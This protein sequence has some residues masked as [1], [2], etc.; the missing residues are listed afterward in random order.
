MATYNPKQPYAPFVERE[1]KKV[2]CTGCMFCTE[3]TGQTREYW[4]YNSPYIFFSCSSQYCIDLAEQLVNGK[5]ELMGINGVIRAF[6][7]LIADSICFESDLPTITLGGVQY[8]IDIGGWVSFE[9]LEDRLN[10]GVI[11]EGRGPY[12]VTEDNFLVHIKAYAPDGTPVRIH[13]M[14]VFSLGEDFAHVVNEHD[15]LHDFCDRVL[16]VER[17]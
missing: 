7:S 14:T 11:Y 1:G 5:D 17:V 4:V 16:V 6:V 12:P 9:G 10:V 13:D 15:D 3:P 2:S 8:S